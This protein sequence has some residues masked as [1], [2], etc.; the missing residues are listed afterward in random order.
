MQPYRVYFMDSSSI[1]AA[2]MIEAAND[3]DAATCA[4]NG[5]G[6]YPWARALMPVRLEVWQGPTFHHAASLAPAE[7]QRCVTNHVH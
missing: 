1:I 4:V 3:R 6:R 2:E 5:L 7:V